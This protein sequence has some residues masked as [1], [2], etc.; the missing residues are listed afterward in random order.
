M[1]KKKQLP[2]RAVML[3]FMDNSPLMV[4]G[5]RLPFAAVRHYPEEQLTYL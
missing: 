4:C 2:Q 3:S 5:I 1:R